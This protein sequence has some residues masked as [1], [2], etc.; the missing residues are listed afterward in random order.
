MR[1]PIDVLVV[2]DDDHLA[3]RLDRLLPS[4]GV[5]IRGA[6]PGPDEAL[7]ELRNDR[8]DV[9]VVG[10][11]DDR[12]RSRTISLCREHEAPV[13]VAS[14]ATEELPAA[15]ALGACGVL[16]DGDAASLLDALRRATAGELVLPVDRLSFLVDGIRPSAVGLGRLTHRE[17]Q[18]VSLFAEGLGT[19]Q[20]AEHLGINVGTVQSHVKNVMAKLGVHS[21][22]EAVRLVLR[23]G[24]ALV[25]RG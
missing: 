25:P 14:S 8:A 24:P 19:A 13:L 3:R 22:V 15:I 5:R 18:V 9:V 21:R 2:D 17:R 16:P 23:E 4:A 1:A 6:V 20:V 10:L 7:G 12:A 11:S